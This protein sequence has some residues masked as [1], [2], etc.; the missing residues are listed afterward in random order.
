[1]KPHG[2]LYNRAMRDPAAA[3]SI[4][5]AV[6]EFDPSLMILCMPASQL[7][8]AAHAA[9]LRPVQEGFLDRAYESATALVARTDPAAVI[10]D[11]DAAA[12]CAERMVLSNV[13]RSVDGV[14]HPIE[15]DSLC[16]HGDNPDA[17]AL[18]R[19]ARARLQARGV[20]IAAFRH[21]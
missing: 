1:V 19:A 2:A 5:A 13:V 14:D 18:M 10:T 15:A 8:A 17:A 4:A 21:S 6:A 11:T 3:N 12:A 7:V 20:T 9:G 16:V